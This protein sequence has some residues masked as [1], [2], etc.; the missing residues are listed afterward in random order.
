MA[1]LITTINVLFAVFY[2]L[3]VVEAVLPWLPHN[4]GNMI[5]RM[6]NAVTGV[7]L[8]PIRLGLPPEKIG[9]DVAPFIAIILGW[10]LQRF[11]VYFILKG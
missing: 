2:V 11:L 5:I 4:R 6:I 9:F 3:L 8:G 7:A 10:F 1:Y